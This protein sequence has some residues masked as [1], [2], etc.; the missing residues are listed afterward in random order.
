MAA[1]S[2]SDISAG[3]LTPQENAAI[4]VFQSK[5]SIRREPSSRLV[6]VRFAT[7]DPRLSAGVVNTLMR[8][9]VERNFEERNEAIAQSSMWLSR[10]L[11]DIRDKMENANN[12][13]AE[14]ATKTGIADVDPNSNTYAEKMGDLNKQLVQAESDRIQFESFLRRG[15]DPDSLPQVRNSPVVQTLLQ[16]LA[17]AEA[18]R[19]QARVLYGPNHLEVRKLESQI[20]ELQALIRVQ[21]AAIVSELST[22]YLAA[23]AR[24]ELLSGEVKDA[25]A[26]LTTLW[27]ST[28]CLRRRRK[29]IVTSTMLSMPKSKKQE[30]LRPPSPATSM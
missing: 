7:H 5:L 9:L 3:Q 18:Q 21:R 8:L 1:R 23:R 4:R 11:D 15:A 12:A 10:Q 29:P 17:E 24:E 28:T 20:S 16:K 26:D 25:T 30:S 2:A 13:L 14:F 27:H 6:G 22:N 19:A